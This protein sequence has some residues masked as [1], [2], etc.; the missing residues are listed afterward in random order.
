MPD[1]MA[2]IGEDVPPPHMNLEGL[3]LVQLIHDSILSP[4]PIGRDQAA[5]SILSALVGDVM[6]EEMRTPA[7]IDKATTDLVNASV[8]IADRL[9]A[10]LEKP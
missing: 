8:V 4:R 7:E 2:H 1:P 10:R 5:L 9:L 6:R 3:A